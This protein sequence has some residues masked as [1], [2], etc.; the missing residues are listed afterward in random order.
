MDGWMGA[1]HVVSCSPKVRDWWA[2]NFSPDKYSGSTNSLYTWNDMNEP[3]VFNGPEVSM[4]K[5]CHAAYP[6]FLVLSLL[7]AVWHSHGFY[8]SAGC[9]EPGWSGASR[10]A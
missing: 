5:V 7:T 8:P 3:S 6:T 4:D 10:V 2:S 1:Q 9:S